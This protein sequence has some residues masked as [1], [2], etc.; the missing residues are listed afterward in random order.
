MKID[1]EHL[2]IPAPVS[3]EV[4]QHT[5]V[6]RSRR[7]ERRSQIGAR[8]SRVGIDFAGCRICRGRCQQ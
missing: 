8:L 6:R 1:V 2:A 5:F 7:L 3:A 4:N